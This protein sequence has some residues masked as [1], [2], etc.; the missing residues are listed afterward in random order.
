MSA[1]PGDVLAFWFAPAPDGAIAARPE[2]FRKD[3]TFD[4]TI[5]TR[6]GS[7]VEHAIA[8]AHDEWRATPRGALALV[9]VLDQFTRNIH[10][11]SARAFAG[12]ARALRIAR[13]VVAHGGD[14][15]LHAYE[16][17]FLYMPFEHAEDIAAQAES[18]ALFTR[19]ARDMG[20]QE[21]LEWAERHAAVVRRFGRFPHRNAF[22]GRASTDDEVAF[23]QTHGSRF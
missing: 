9:I 22:V 7:L 13:S 5:R 17:W 8:G 15:L 20:S 6:F 19:L 16:R 4:T 23:L 14:A 3:H 21:P 18:I 10:R 11:D 2:W 12:D 1:T